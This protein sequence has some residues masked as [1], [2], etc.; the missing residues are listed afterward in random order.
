MIATLVVVSTATLLVV[1]G[2]NYLA[3]KRTLKAIEDNLTAGIENKGKGLVT[4]QGLGLRDLVMDNAFGDVARL[5]E[6]TIEKDEQLVYGLF[7]DE[8]GKCWGFATRQ[9]LSKEPDDWKRLAIDARDLK[10]GAKGSVEMR[11]R[12]VLSQTAFEFFMLV[13]D[14]KG[15][16]LGKLFYALSDRPLQYALAEARADSRRNL[17]VTVG[18]FLLLGTV[19][20][21][22]GA[23]RSKQSAV[24]ITQPVIDLTEAVNRLASGK[25]D[26][27]VQ[28][29]SGDELEILGGAFNKMV[30][31]LKDSYE[32]LENMNRT[33]E[34]K[35]QERTR[36]L[37]ERNRDMRLVMDNVN[38]GF[39]TVSITG[40]LAQ[41]RSA[42][43]DRWFG[44]Y[45]GDTQFSD[46]IAQSDSLYAASFKMGYEA[47]IEDVLPREL[48]I[49]QLPARLRRDGR[50]YRCSYFAILKGEQLGGL[51]IV[52]ND[53]T[54]ELLHARQE[55]ERKEILAMFEALTKDRS[56]FLSFMDEA[57]EIFK[58]VRQGDLAV[59]KRG[60]HTLKGNAGLVGFGIVANLCHQAEDELAERTAPLTAESL[61]PLEERWRTLS[62]AF[63]TFLGDK[64]RDVLELSTKELEKLE[65]EIRA[66]A[67]TTHVLDRLASWWL[68]P[69]EL[70]LKRLGR[71]AAALTNRLGKGDL[72]LQIQS[73]GVRLAPKAWAG[74]WTD[75][76]HV[77][78]NAVDHGFERPAEREAA[79]K[80]PR[81]K[82]RLS[83]VVTGHK[84]VVEIE[85]FGRGIDWNAV[86]V[87]AVKHGLPSATEEDL[88][89]AMFHSG[90]STAAEVTTISGRGVGLSAVRQQ[91]EDLGG[92]I[93]VVS[94]PNQGTCFRFTFT[95]AE[96][97]PRFGVDTT[98]EFPIVGA[99]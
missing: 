42:I 78:R 82:I 68:E 6:R 29:T 49:E 95:L 53:V 18:L 15:A 8:N 81:P 17:L 34:I 40:K 69:A 94:K 72:E 31:E 52:I 39:L 19:A 1:A 57:N 25:R 63:K 22:M 33:L 76:V 64:G 85:D 71:Y 60:L 38:Q 28:I 26:I 10:G 91:V 93:S 12:R 43:V 98:G 14:D 73:H 7:V 87:A 4:N 88:V 44:S 58:Q 32:R 77:V 21:I 74:F 13:V 23:I 16:P 66:G 54:S 47:L 61:A 90:L 56:G 51:L 46:Y 2:M 30:A 5:L 80:G 27:S 67:P 99:A 41:E 59:Q 45:E 50:E 62:E 97:G 89:A 11:Y 3:S 55:A 86:R 20:V 9:G 48:C 96:V 92:H 70:P 36:E 79:G 35:V 24:R 65:Q 83:S 37:G 75:L 84:L